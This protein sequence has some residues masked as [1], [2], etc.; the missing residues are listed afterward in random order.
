MVWERERERERVGG[1]LAPSQ[2]SPSGG[3][4]DC[5]VTSSTIQAHLLPCVHFCLLAWFLAGSL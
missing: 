1:S 5:P 2:G 4:H 3:G